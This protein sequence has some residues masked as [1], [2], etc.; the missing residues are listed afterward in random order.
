MSLRHCT[1]SSSTSWPD[2]LFSISLNRT[3]LITNSNNLRWILISWYRLL[4]WN[5][6]NAAAMCVSDG[7]SEIRKFDI[8]KLLLKSVSNSRKAIKLCGA[9]V[10]TNIS[11]YSFIKHISRKCVCQRQSSFF[12]FWENKCILFACMF[13]GC[14]GIYVVFLRFF[15]RKIMQKP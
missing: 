11:N 14:P 3:S 4:L 6:S 5:V 12:F 7:T 15:V 13:V 2:F 9:Y 10:Y 1:L 8:I